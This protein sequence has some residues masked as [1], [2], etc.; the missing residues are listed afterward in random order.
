[1]STGTD[2]HLDTDSLVLY[3]TRIM[4]AWNS[5]C[6]CSE[7]GIIFSTVTS[8]YVSY[9]EYLLGDMNLKLEDELF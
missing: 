9:L 2:K 8:M 7:T 5:E 3:S 4:N 6:L 1:M